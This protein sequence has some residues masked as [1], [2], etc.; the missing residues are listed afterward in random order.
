MNMKKT[1]AIGIIALFIGL[2]FTPVSSAQAQIEEK[3]TKIPIQISSL[4]ADGRIGTQTISLSKTDLSDLIDIMDSLKK[5]GRNPGDLLDRL[6]NLFDRDNG[7][8]DDIGLLSK[9]QGNTIVSIGEG[10]Q[11][12]SRYHGRVQLKKL[13]SIWNY[14]G[15]IGATMIWGDGL[16]SMPTQVLL[17]KQI[18]IMV[19]F[20]GVYMYIPPLLE[21][22]NSKT[23]FMGSAMF[24]WGVSA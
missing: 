23:F 2:S 3:D 21:D 5:P 10:R 15:D 11:L 17:Q 4:T 9:L 8:F 12:L 18:G 16:T 20:V 19:G 14:P 13:V 1:L 24:A 22:M 6:K 7:L